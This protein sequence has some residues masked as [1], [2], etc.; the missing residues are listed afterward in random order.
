MPSKINKNTCQHESVAV[1]CREWSSY[2]KIPSSNLT[3]SS[4]SITI[5]SITICLAEP[6]ALKSLKK[7]HIY[8][9]IH[10]EAWVSWFFSG[11]KKLRELR[12]IWWII[13]YGNPVEYINIYIHTWYECRNINLSIDSLFVLNHIFFW[14]PV[15]SIPIL[16]RVCF[17]PVNGQLVK[18]ARREPFASTFWARSER[19]L[20]WEMKT[21]T[22]IQEESW[23]IERFIF[24]IISQPTAVLIAAHFFAWFLFTWFSG[25]FLKL[26][27]ENPAKQRILVDVS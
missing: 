27:V 3:F 14:K 16:N 15:D 5:E 24:F 19:D 6:L 13:F 9:Y 8:I 2:L 25:C 1:R 20:N 18:F 11:F 21:I 4:A 12:K 23:C 10:M 7:H 17:L 22:V 26:R